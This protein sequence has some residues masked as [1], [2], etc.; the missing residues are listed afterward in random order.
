MERDAVDGKPK[1]MITYL[2]TNNT[3]ASNGRAPD[4][5]H[6]FQNIWVWHNKQKD[7]DDGRME[8]KSEGG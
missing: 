8:V 3:Y 7:D 1:S 2:S 6:Y 5:G 4:D